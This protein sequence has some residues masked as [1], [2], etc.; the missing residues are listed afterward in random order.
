MCRLH[1]SISLQTRTFNAGEQLGHTC[2]KK[3]CHLWAQSSINSSED[4]DDDSWSRDGFSCQL[5]LCTFAHQWCWSICT[6]ALGKPTI[7][8][9]WLWVCMQF[10]VFLY[11]SVSAGV[12]ECQPALST[13]LFPKQKA[14]LHWRCCL[15]WSLIKPMCACGVWA[16]TRSSAGEWLRHMAH[17]QTQTG[18]VWHHISSLRNDGDLF[19]LPLCVCSVLVLAS[20]QQ[21]ST[22]LKRMHFWSIWP[23]VSNT[24]H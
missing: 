2:S 21:H 22:Y 3:G 12:C 17:K 11:V 18:T 9:V 19:K 10:A 24:H 23:M 4:W 14:C 7:D 1:F 8:M 16:S 15:Y 5:S 6:Y 13:D 20:W